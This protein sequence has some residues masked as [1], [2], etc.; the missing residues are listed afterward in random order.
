M[1]YLKDVYPESPEDEFDLATDWIEAMENRQPGGGENCGETAGD[2]TIVVEVAQ[3]KRR[4]MVRRVLGFAYADETDD[5]T[6]RLHRENPVRHPVFPTMRATAINF[7]AFPPDGS[8]GTLKAASVFDSPDDVP[9]Y[10]KYQK[11]YATVKFRSFRCQFYDDFDVFNNAQELYRNTYFDPASSVEM[12]SAEGPLGQM[13][14]A[15]TG[16]APPSQPT[17]G[18]PIK[19]TFGT[20]V[21]K[22]VYVLN[23]LRVPHEWISAEEYPLCDF[24]KI[25]AI[26]GRV[27]SSEFGRFPTGTLCAQPPKYSPFQW[28]VS[29]NKGVQGFYGWDIQI[30]FQHFDPDKGVPASA[31]RGFQL[32]PWA[33]TLKWYH[34]V[35]SDPTVTTHL[36]P[37]TDFNNLFK[38]ATMA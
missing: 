19:Q 2:A 7:S 36:L 18:E 23:W 26:V 22:N 17:V 11:V 30:P 15:E 4:S 9:F 20:L 13:R 3:N 25:N 32:L 29:S 6:A 31:F 21:S 14:W 38:K 34:A 5:A 28:Q 33:P 8:G 16:A 37:E 1:P 27:N 12:L 10:A 35:R 24:R